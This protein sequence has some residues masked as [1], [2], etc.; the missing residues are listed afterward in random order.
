MTSRPTRLT[1]FAATALLASSG[2][3]VAQSARSADA[4]P[5]PVSPMTS[6]QPA[7]ADRDMQAVLDQLAH[8][9]ANRSKR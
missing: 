4:A 7:K 3:A 5:P 9:V 6:V 1:A 2:M 8:L